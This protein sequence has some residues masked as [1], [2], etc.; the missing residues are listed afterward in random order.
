MLRCD[1]DTVLVS[2][3]AEPIF[4]AGWSL[5]R[6]RGLRTAFWCQVTHDA[7][8]KRRWWK[9]HI[10]RWMFARVDATFGH[11]AESQRFAIKNGARPDRARTLPHSIDVNFF[12]TASAEA[13]ADRDAIRRRLGCEG[14]TFIYVGRLWSGKGVDIL[15][16]AFARVQ[17]QIRQ[18]ISL[19]LVGDGKQEPALRRWVSE[20]GIR[21]VIFP[22]FQDKESLPSYYSAADVFVFPTL[23]DPYGL[24]VDEAMACG[25]PILS[26]DAAGEIRERV[27]P[28][29]NGL[30]VPANA[31]ELMANAMESLATD[32]QTARVASEHI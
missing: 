29:Q 17:G 31:I 4:I 12:S 1:R 30:L 14:V 26:T 6:V 22:G 23:G 25:L 19:L 32:S 15:L 3:Y 18:P 27:I 7:W 2:L 21:N 16:K 20:Q 8:I 28:G 11:G 13:R 10:K 24:V 9:N 5:A